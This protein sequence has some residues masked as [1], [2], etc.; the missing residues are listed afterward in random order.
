[1]VIIWIFGHQLTFT[2]FCGYVIYFFC[3]HPLGK[4]DSLNYPCK[5]VIKSDLTLI[6]DR[7]MTEV[8]IKWGINGKKSH[9]YF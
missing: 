4:L 3:Q 2:A 7:F 1:M 8:M 9:R 6:Y 5:M